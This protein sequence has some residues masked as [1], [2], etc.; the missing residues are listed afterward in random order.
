[1]MNRRFPQTRSVLASDRPWDK[2]FLQNRVPLSL[3]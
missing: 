1:V 2:G 3:N